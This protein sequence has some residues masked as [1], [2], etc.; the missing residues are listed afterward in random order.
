[1]ST[2]HVSWAIQKRG[3]VRADTWILP[4]ALRWS[5]LG[6]SRCAGR[7]AVVALR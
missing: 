3:R 2:P 5:P 7:A 4:I 6:W 1:M